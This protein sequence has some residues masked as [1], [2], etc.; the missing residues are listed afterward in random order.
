MAEH[1]SFEKALT[2]FSDA[3]AAQ[4]RSYVGKVG[5]RFVAIYPYCTPDGTFI[6]GQIRLREGDSKTF[7]A[8]HFVGDQLVFKKPAKP[9]G[10][11]PLFGSQLVAK[12]PLA[13]VMVCEGEKATLAV[14]NHARHMNQLGEWIAVTSGG[15][16][17]AKTANWKCLEGRE[18]VIWADNDSPGF[19]YASDVSSELLSIARTCAYVDVG[20]LNL[21]PAGD[22][23]DWV[24]AQPG[25]G[26]M[27]LSELP[28]VWDLPGVGRA[29]SD[30]SHARLASPLPLIRE[31]DGRS[32]F[33]I[34]ALGPMLG[35]AARAMANAVQCPPALA[36]NSVLASAALAVQGHADVTVDGRDSP[37][38]LYVLSIAKSGERKT[39]VEKLA[40]APFVRKQ[41]ADQAIYKRELKAYRAMLKQLPKGSIEPDAPTDPT[42]L[43]KDFTI[44]ALVRGLIHGRPSQGIFLSEGGTFL[45][46]YSMGKDS[47]LRTSST[48]SDV[49][50]GE[51]ISQSRVTGR[52]T[53]DCRRISIHLQVQ[54]DIVADFVGNEQIQSQGFLQRFLM[55]QPESSIGSRRY[56]TV[57]VKLEPAYQA[58]IARLDQLIDKPLNVDDNGDLVLGTVVL[59]DAAY[60]LWIDAY[61]AIEQASAPDGLLE[62]YQAY[63]SK[64]PE[65]IL[66]MA[67]IIALFE[68]PEVVEIPESTMQGAIVLAQH[69]LHEAMNL[70]LGPADRLLSRAKELLDWL[71]RHESPIALRDVYRTGPKFV[72]SAAQARELLEILISHGWVKRHD[73]KITAANGKVSCEN[74]AVVADV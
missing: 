48:L 63:A 3:Q 29:I 17:S 46:G 2:A 16:Q 42:I 39:A 60:F 19:S 8:F 25:S 47:L 4:I 71:R 49:W 68:D 5:D 65:Q 20:A 69:Y 44:D 32:D 41:R 70:L 21:G 6:F 30:E 51:G 28:F 59:S 56:A 61:N 58:Y 1:T 33:P 15:A 45:G 55:S 23:A 74:Y 13:S 43:V 26:A 53:A 73:G 31:G 67:A 50:S 12:F 18:V 66:R 35:S 64:L 57:N 10:G 34:D 37:L 22:A 27:S 24:A 40:N 11:Y 36:G 7:R 38:A 54:P 62:N 72:R 14:I 52:H 9:D